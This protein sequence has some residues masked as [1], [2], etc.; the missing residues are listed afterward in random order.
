[1]HYEKVLA[2]FR[3]YIEGFGTP[4][5]SFTQ[6]RLFLSSIRS[7]RFYSSVIHIKQFEIFEDMFNLFVDMFCKNS[8]IYF[9]MYN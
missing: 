2:D 8:E 3:P 1:M 5:M 7:E 9:D 4:R 6:P